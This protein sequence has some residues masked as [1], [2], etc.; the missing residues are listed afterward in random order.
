MK[1][2]YLLGV[3]LLLWSVA[4]WGQTPDEG[5]ASQLKSYVEKR[6]AGEDAEAGRTPQINYDYLC[7]TTQDLLKTHIIDHP[8]SVPNCIVQID[9][10]YVKEGLL[11]H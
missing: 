3:L 7:I 9:N 4:V 10:Y 11:C 8:I 6:V 1:K 5:F 2:S